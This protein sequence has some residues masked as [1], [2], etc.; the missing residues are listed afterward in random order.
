MDLITWAGIVWAASAVIFVAFERLVIKDAGVWDPKDPWVS[1]TVYAILIIFSPALLVLA[2]VVG[3]VGAL[4]WLY[5]RLFQGRTADPFT[6][7]EKEW[8]TDRDLFLGQLIRRRKVFDSRLKREDIGKW[9]MYRFGSMPDAAVLRA[10]DVHRDLAAAGVPDSAIWE[11]LD[12]FFAFEGEPLVD[13]CGVVGYLTSRLKSYDPIFVDL[14]KEFV[15]GHVEVCLRWLAII[16]PPGGRIWPPMEWLT[17]Q[18]TLAE[19]EKNGDGADPFADG[20]PAVLSLGGRSSREFDAL[21]VRMLAGDE[22]W[23]YSSPPESWAKLCGRAG[24]ALVRDGRP[25]AHLV[26]MMN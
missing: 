7:P 6:A 25:I 20:A 1:G 3:P 18:I 19:F 8:P 5:G 14:G 23:A 4:R 13:G 2:A 11:K 24:I 26:T 16:S 12:A 9:P 15:S 21:K 10:A 22:I 17:H